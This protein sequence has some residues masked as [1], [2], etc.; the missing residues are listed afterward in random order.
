[1]TGPIKSEATGGNGLGAFHHS[2]II[3]PFA[4]TAAP[5]APSQTFP[6]S[7]SLTPVPHCPRR[8]A[9]PHFLL[10]GSPHGR[11]LCAGSAAAGEL[12]LFV[13]LPGAAVAGL[14]ARPALQPSRLPKLLRVAAR[15]WR[16]HRRVL[17]PHA[18]GVF[19]AGLPSFAAGGREREASP[20]AIVTAIFPAP[21]SSQPASPGPQASCAPKKALKLAGRA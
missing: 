7:A 4:K 11:S 15:L 20:V 10:T 2:A 14:P 21:S 16:R 1:M 3:S 6:A 9:P 18:A 17:H 5:P 12:T 8:P 19:A 13:G